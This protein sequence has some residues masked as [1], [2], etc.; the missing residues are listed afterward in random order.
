MRQ[1]LT[2]SVVL[3]L[4]AG[5]LAGLVGC[6]EPDNGGPKVEK[7]P[8]VEKQ[9]EAPKV[10]KAPILTP[11]PKRTAAPKTPKVA[12]APKVAEKVVVKRISAGADADYVTAAGV[13]WLADREYTEKGGFGAIGGKTIVRESPQTV[14]G[15]DAPKVYLT[16]RYSM[17]AYRFNLPNGKYTVRLHFAE[18]YDGITQAGER[19]FTVKVQGK[20]ALADFDV[21]KIG[22]GFAKPVV[23]DVAAE[24]TDGKLMIEFVAKV[25]N[26]EINGIEVVTGGG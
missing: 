23:K 21:F 5:F 16:E 3:C 2:V 6:A 12:K 8:K 15:T 4:A 25:Q 14:A 17:D 26:A 9:E 20:A 24:V 7:T 1:V 22:G 18:T 10:D 19:V 13:K 11:G